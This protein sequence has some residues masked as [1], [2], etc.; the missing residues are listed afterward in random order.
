MSPQHGETWESYLSPFLN[1]PLAIW[2]HPSARIYIQYILGFITQHEAAGFL[3]NKLNLGN[4]VNWL[5]F[6]ETRGRQDLGMPLP[7]I[8]IF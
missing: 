4:F 2:L 3:G 6:L 7:L 5:V 8:L 1:G